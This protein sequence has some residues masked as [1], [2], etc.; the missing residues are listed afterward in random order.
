M[1]AARQIEPRAYTFAATDLSS[2]P[3][4]ADNRCNRGGSARRLGGTLFIRTGRAACKAVVRG[5]RFDGALLTP[6]E[7]LGARTVVSYLQSPSHAER[8]RVRKKTPLSTLPAQHPRVIT[9]T[10]RNFS[11]DTASLSFAS[12]ARRARHGSVAGERYAPAQSWRKS[13]TGGRTARCR[14]LP[15]CGRTSSAPGSGHG[16]T[17]FARRPL[18]PGR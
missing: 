7:S 3:S 18:D 12:V 11:Q 9:L 13:K 15:R 10:C 8:Q 17:A 2:L 6:L 16:D 5:S 4:L 1:G 14:C